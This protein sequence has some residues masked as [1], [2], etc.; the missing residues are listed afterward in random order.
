VETILKGGGS[1]KLAPQ[2]GKVIQF[3]FRHEVANS[4][5]P[6]GEDTEDG[7]LE[8]SFICY[9]EKHKKDMVFEEIMRN[10]KLPDR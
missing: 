9:F 1:V 5:H 10:L 4:M 7:E 2:K 3:V 8:S 6:K